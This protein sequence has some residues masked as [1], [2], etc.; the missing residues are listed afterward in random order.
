MPHRVCMRA[1]ARDRNRMSSF[2]LRFESRTGEITRVCKIDHERHK[3][4]LRT[5]ARAWSSILGDAPSSGLF[6][7]SRLQRQRH[8]QGCA[9]VQTSLSN[10]ASRT[11]R[12]RMERRIRRCLATAGEEGD[13]SGDWARLSG[14]PW[15]QRRSWR[16]DEHDRIHATGISARG[17]GGSRLTNGR[18]T[19]PG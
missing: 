16:L 9:R 11:G 19:N 15:L 17:N 2:F 18:D 5:K 1:A 8:L 13:S 4:R 10:E 6:A 14:R 7:R 12:T 3:A